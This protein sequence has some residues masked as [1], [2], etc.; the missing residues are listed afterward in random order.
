MLVSYPGLTLAGSSFFILLI[1][2]LIFIKASG[3]TVFL[4]WPG[5][6][7]VQYCVGNYQ[8]VAHRG[9]SLAASISGNLFLF[10]FFTALKI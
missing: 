6:G 9:D 1:I 4:H 2:R 8:Y 5:G 10:D 3:R 7:I